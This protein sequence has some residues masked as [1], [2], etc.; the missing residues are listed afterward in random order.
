MSQKAFL[1]LFSK[2]EKIKVL[3]CFKN[4]FNSNFR[5]PCPPILGGK[6]VESPPRLGDLGGKFSNADFCCY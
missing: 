6:V 5:P 4:Y 2:G 1:L 3:V